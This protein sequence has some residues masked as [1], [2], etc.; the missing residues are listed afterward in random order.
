MSVLER[1]RVRVT[2]HV[3]AQ[4]MLF[5]HGFGCDQ[6]M[7]RLVAPVFAED[8]RVVLFDHLGSGGSDVDAYDEAAYSGL[9][10]YAQDVLDICHELDLH[11]VVFVGHSVSSMI[12]VLAQIAEPDVFARLVMVG[13]SARYIDDGDYVGGFSEADIDELLDLM[14]SNHLGWQEPLSGMVMPGPELAEQRA[15]LDA[16][17][18]RTRPDIARRFAGVTFRGDNRADLP[19]VSVPTLV[20][21]N[22]NDPIAPPSAGAYV[23]DHVPG[24]VLEVIETSGHCAHLSAPS[25]T[26]AAIRAFVLT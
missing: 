23:R 13:P 18:C 2:G 15:E 26:I 17:F 8:F 1:H 25:E 19:L 4:P 20:L 21:Q 9:E 11:D 3:D 10:R 22:S 12:G 6:A 16:S 5:A 14:D 24:A 7:W